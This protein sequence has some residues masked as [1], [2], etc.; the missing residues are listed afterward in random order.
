VFAQRVITADQDGEECPICKEVFHA[1][2][3]VPTLPCLHAVHDRCLSAWIQSQGAETCPICRS[4]L[5][6]G[7]PPA[8]P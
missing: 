6:G 1:G 8:S 7:A 5:S 4:A 2:E 3:H